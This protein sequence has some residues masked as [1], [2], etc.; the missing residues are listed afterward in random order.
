MLAA[1]LGARTKKCLVKIIVSA[2][3]SWPFFNGYVPPKYIHVFF[4]NYP[5]LIG[6]HLDYFLVLV[7]FVL[8]VLGYKYHDSYT[9]TRICQ[10]WGSTYKKY[11][12]RISKG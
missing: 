6:K 1:A 11:V 4:K 8:S 3:T 12:A 9:C 10:D 5:E 7:Y 2:I